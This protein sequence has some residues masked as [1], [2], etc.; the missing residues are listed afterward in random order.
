[1]KL[2]VRIWIVC[3]YVV[4]QILSGNSR[5][6]IVENIHSKLMEIG[7]KVKDG[8]IPLDLYVITKVSKILG[9]VVDVSQVNSCIIEINS[10]RQ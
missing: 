4:D 6:A 2:V 10:N 8:Q 5:E 9:Y 1:M 3:S 7:Q